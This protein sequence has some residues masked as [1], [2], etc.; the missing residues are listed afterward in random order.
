MILD[1]KIQQ[2]L[3][4]QNEGSNCLPVYRIQLLSVFTVIT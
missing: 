4:L 3:K 2:K 1:N